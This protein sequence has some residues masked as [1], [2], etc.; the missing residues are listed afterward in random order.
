MRNTRIMDKLRATKGASLAVAL[1]YFMICAAVGS[2]VLTAAMAN[3]SLVKTEKM[4]EGS[5]LAVMSA[6]TALKEQ[7]K[8]AAG[9][10]TVDHGS[11]ESPANAEERVAFKEA[12]LPEIDGRSTSG[13]LDR[14][15][16]RV[17]LKC[18]K[19]G[20]HLSVPAQ[21]ADKE[22][23]REKL[24]LTF[25]LKEDGEEKTVPP[26][27]ADIYFTPDYVVMDSAGAQQLQVRLEA[28]LAID[29]EGGGGQYF[30]NMSCNGVI[31]YTLDET[32]TEV[33]A[34][35]NP[36]TGE[37]LSEPKYIY[38][39]ESRAVISSDRPVFSGRQGVLGTGGEA[40]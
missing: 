1:V 8:G 16:Y 26:V 38:E 25:A 20:D 34:E 18:L 19:E 2:V 36:E 6:G 37:A 33:E 3:L 32:V 4:N 7:L 40:E 28:A 9:E 35:K 22:A 27:K 21:R 24:S 13:A 15:F 10:W 39:Y 23:L 5:Y 31:Y 11:Q 17:Y 14:A 29:S 30:L 12:L